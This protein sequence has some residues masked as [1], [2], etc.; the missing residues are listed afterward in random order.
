MGLNLRPLFA[1]LPPLLGDVRADLGLSAAAAGLLTTGP[2]LC[3]G[4][5]APLGPR[6]VRRMPVERLLVGCG[7]LSAAGLA[8][9]G[10]GGT[11]ALFAG[12]LAAGAAV[13]CAQVVLPALARARHPERAGLLT[14]LIS[15]SLVLGA[16][17]AAFGAV[18]LERAFGGSWA[19]A[20]AVWA[21][22]A[23]VA[24][25]AW[26]PAARRARGG[27]PAREGHP[28]WRIPLAWSVA[29]FFGVQSMGFYATLAWVP[30]IL[31]ASGTSKGGAGSLLALSA[32]VQFGPAF[33]VPAFAA[34]TRTQLPWLIVVVA[35]TLTGV[36]GL[37]AAPG[38]AVLWM[39][40]LGLGQGAALGLGLVLPVLRGRD[41]EAV[42]SLTA[43]AF[44][45]GYLVAAA[46]PWLL[47]AVRDASGGWTAPLIVLCVVTVLELPAG[48]L[49]VRD[50]TL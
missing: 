8:L 49:A 6:L 12:T 43:M 17:A 34:R 16:A 36:V 25:V 32:L 23:V 42:A 33:A 26:T 28:L 48:L 41:A 21:V 14:G 29:L 35:L 46:G 24:T 5:L 11:V 18:P 20:L 31:E 50:R 37:L 38:A 39:V 15:M 7:V 4:A 30:S 10:A 27:V 22:L 1:S 2:V 40:I 44:G 9:R 47:G 19:A 13:A 3:L 45:L